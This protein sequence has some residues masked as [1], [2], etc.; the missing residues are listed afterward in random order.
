MKQLSNTDTDLLVRAWRSAAETHKREPMDYASRLYTTF[1]RFLFIKGIRLISPDV[2]RS[3]KSILE[4][5]A[6]LL[7][8]RAMREVLD[9]KGELDDADV[10]VRMISATTEEREKA[11]RLLRGQGVQF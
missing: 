4:R 6:S 7:Y 5:G 11:I 8:I 2:V 3:E 10:V 1:M 9:P